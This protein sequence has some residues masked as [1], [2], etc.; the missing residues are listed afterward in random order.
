MQVLAAA[1]G[2]AADM[3]PG[4]AVTTDLDGLDLD[5]IAT[6]AACEFAASVNSYEGEPA[7][8]ASDWLSERQQATRYSEPQAAVPQD[9]DTLNVDCSIPGHEAACA[10]IMGV[11]SYEGQESAL[12]RRRVVEEAGAQHAGVSL[13]EVDCGSTEEGMQQECEAI[14]AANSYETI[15]EPAAADQEE[16]GEQVNCIPRVRHCMVIDVM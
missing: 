15:G 4:T 6:P 3:Q 8:A 13:L 1:D 14:R 16:Q 9:L 11:N 12:E 5:C 7:E 10:A 2:E